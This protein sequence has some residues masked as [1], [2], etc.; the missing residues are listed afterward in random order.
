MSKTLDAIRRRPYVLAVDD[1]RSQGN[2]II[3]TLK[4]PFCYVG[5]KDCGVQGF[6]NVTD[7]K[8]GTAGANVYERTP[9]A[10]QSK[11]A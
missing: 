7:A 4:Q 1:E 2:S 3:I 6:D 10:G 11:G 9:D 5:E 8:R